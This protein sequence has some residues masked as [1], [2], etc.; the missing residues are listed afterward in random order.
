M[1]ICTYKWPTN[2][3]GSMVV[4]VGPGS[5]PDFRRVTVTMDV[6]DEYELISNNGVDLPLKEVESLVCHLSLLYHYDP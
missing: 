1:S 6:N 2:F 5:R 4:L 3:G